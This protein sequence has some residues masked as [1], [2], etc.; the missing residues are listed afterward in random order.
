MAEEVL[1]NETLEEEEE[2][3]NKITSWIEEHPRIVFW[4]RFVF[5][6][7]FACILPFLFI[8]WRYERFG[9]VGQFQ[10]SG[11]G[12]I[13]IIIVF[14]FA[15]TVIKYIK[16]ALS[17]RYTL[18]GQILG[19]FC[20]IILPLLTVLAILKSIKDNID[21]AMT[22]LSVV[23]VCQAVAIPLNPLPKWA[24]E[25]QKDVR[26]DEKKEA[27]DYLLDGFFKRKKD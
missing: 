14:V 6:S 19:G 4:L 3:K 9:K 17:A 21:V 20:K 2:K 22:V 7:L 24:Y 13:G 8:A 15:L 18:I 25:M 11:W 12:I 27:M 1:K 23:T 16:L 26:D 10:L 5:W